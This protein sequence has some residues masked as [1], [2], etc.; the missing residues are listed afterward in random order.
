MSNEEV[1]RRINHGPINIIIKIRK[2]KWIGHTLR[3]PQDD[4]TR[5]D[6][7]WNPAGRRGRP[8]QT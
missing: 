8:R 3:K 2:W 1:C 7:E 6:L 4:I 5:Q